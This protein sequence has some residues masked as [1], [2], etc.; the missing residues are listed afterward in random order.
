VFEL[1]YFFSTGLR[2]E[3]GDTASSKKIKAII[4]DMIQKENR[5]KPLSDQEVGEILKREG[6]FVARRTVAKY[7]DQLGIFSA[8][9]RKQY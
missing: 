1:K 9:M 3:H 7:R 6:F 5:G 4:E 8:R 2:T